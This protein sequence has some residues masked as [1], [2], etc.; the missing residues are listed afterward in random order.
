[1][2]SRFKHIKTTGFN[3]PSN[4][5]SGLENH[6]S[7]RVNTRMAI[8]NINQ[9]GF[10]IPNNYFSIVENNI[11]MARDNYPGPIATLSLLTRRNILYLSGIAA[12]LILIFNVFKTKTK[13]SFDTIDNALVESYLTTLD[14]NN[15]DLIML[16]EDTDLNDINLITYDFLDEAIQDH[17]FN[18][19]TLEELLIE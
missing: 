1:M 18:N 11:L 16:W 9:T 2:R 8:K 19:L 12:S 13:V 17:I 4:Y 3:V 6:L 7:N 14:I 10:K 15:S 5:L